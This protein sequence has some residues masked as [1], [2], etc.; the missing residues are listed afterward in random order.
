MCHDK[1]KNQM[2]TCQVMRDLK[3]YC[4]KSAIIQFIENPEGSVIGVFFLY[5]SV[6]ENC[7]SAGRKTNIPVLLQFLEERQKSAVWNQFK[8]GCRNLK[9]III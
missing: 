5:V 3:H 8:T 6:G 2:S 1:E 4:F 7:L 9:G